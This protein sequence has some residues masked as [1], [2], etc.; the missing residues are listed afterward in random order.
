VQ[1][2]QARHLGGT[3]DHIMEC[4]PSDLN[5]KGTKGGIDGSAT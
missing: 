3:A 2:E 1:E 5:V 4:S